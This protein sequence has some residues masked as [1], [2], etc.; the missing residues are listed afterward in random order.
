MT[1]PVG[2]L[3]AVGVSV[4]EVLA[5]LAGCDAAATVALV[6]GISRLTARLQG[7]MIHAQ[8]HLARLRPP[9]K[10]SP[11]DPPDSPYS[12]FAAD[13]LAAELRQSPRAMSDRLLTA[14][15]MAHQLPSGLAA[16]TG[17][18]LDYARLAAL[19]QLTLCLTDGQRA[20]VEK[21]M[22]AGGRLASAPQWRRKI[23]RLVAKVA[24]GALARRR[25]EAHTRRSVSVKP[26]EDGMALLEATL[27]AEDARAIFDR[28]DRVAR[29]DG[30]PAGP[31]D[32]RSL[33]ARRADVLAAL[34]LGN[35]REHVTVEL[36]VIAP[37]GTLAGLDDNPAEL[38]GYGPIPA[39]VGRALAADAHWR[40]VLTDPATGTVLD[41]G[42]RRVPTPALARLVRHQ[43]SCC[44]FPGCGMPAA[45]ADIDHTVGH[46]SGGRTS[47]DNLGMLCRHHH[48]AKHAVGG[49]RLDQPTAGIFRWI[50]PA[51]RT[52]T[53][54]TTSNDEEALPSG[55]H[56]RNRPTTG[57]DNPATAPISESGQPASQPRNIGPC[58]F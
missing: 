33:D 44:V 56:P 4:D 28:L 12:E 19:H 37:I 25:A 14:W 30:R 18:S 8:V 11:D 51:G 58:P 43:Q 45:S 46:A 23:R 32:D 24:P 50:S 6:S 31:R 7:L 54:D 1:A 42:H 2:R 35:R 52:Y 41:L 3:D 5:E 10:G 40:R 17:G 57:T 21:T 22:L 16:L 36:Q 49:W 47:L 53:T 26:L 13:E 55:T 29:S 39:E 9:T 34:L 15:E 38:V 27:A 48:R 20:F